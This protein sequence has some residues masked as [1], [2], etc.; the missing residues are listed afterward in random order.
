MSDRLSALRCDYPTLALDVWALRTA[1]RDIVADVRAGAE[2]Q[3]VLTRILDGS[4]P[5][6]MPAL[7]REV[8]LALREWRPRPESEVPVA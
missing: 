5:L 8:A 4:D 7:A 2:R 1:A 3:A 6:V